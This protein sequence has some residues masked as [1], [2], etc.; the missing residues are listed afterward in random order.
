[1]LLPSPLE[2]GDVAMVMVEVALVV[3]DFGC[4]ET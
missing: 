1:M 4:W 3:E 2:G